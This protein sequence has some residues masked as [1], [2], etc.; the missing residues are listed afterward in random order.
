MVR[1]KSEV[2]GGTLSKTSCFEDQ[3][4]LGPVKELRAP[5]WKHCGWY[6]GDRLWIISLFVN[7]YAIACLECMRGDVAWNNVY[8]VRGKS[9]QIIVRSPKAKSM[10]YS[11]VLGALNAKVVVMELLKSLWLLVIASL[12]DFELC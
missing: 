4:G 10:L 2:C 11:M 9:T 7:H 12:V 1:A 5:I 3:R 8:I 6:D